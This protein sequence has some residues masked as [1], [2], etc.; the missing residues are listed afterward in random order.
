[1][2]I[3]SANKQHPVPQNVM[4]VE[5]KLIGELT[6]RQFSY[7]L[8]FAVIAFLT[9]KTGL[10]VIFKYP[11][12]LVF[13]LSGLAFA[14][15]PFND[16]TLDKWVS[17][18]IRAVTN[19]RFRV[20]KHIQRVPYYFTLDAKKQDQNNSQIKQVYNQKQRGSI[21]EFL[22]KNKPSNVAFDD[23]SDI[24]ATENEFFSKLGL[25]TSNKTVKPISQPVTQ[26]TPQGE[27]VKPENLHKEMFEDETHTK[28][29]YTSLALDPTLPVKTFQENAKPLS[30]QSDTDNAKKQEKV[31]AAQYQ[32][33]LKELDSLKKQLL[34]DIEKN[35]FKIRDD[36]KTEIQNLNS[37]ASISNPLNKNLGTEEQLKNREPSLKQ[38][39]PAEEK[40]QDMIEQKT[41]QTPQP[42]TSLFKSLFSALGSN[43]AADKVEVQPTNNTTEVK[44]KTPALNDVKPNILKGNTQ[45]I[46]GNIIQD[47]IVIIKNSD[48]DPVRALKT[49]AL[50]E[51]EVSTPLD[52]GSYKIEA[53]KEGFSFTPIEV[54]ASGQVINPVKLIGTQ[55]TVLS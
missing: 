38:E 8:V 54:N 5:F 29:K 6:I 34:K 13:I 53:I 18:Y 43:T 40:K 24:Q 25:N 11:L 22:N 20:W 36:K 50:G 19:P 37:N 35:K 9:A 33:H 30:Q 16:I 41:T 12:I 26:S 44:E 17:N 51:F 55:V 1:M 4:D 52:E 15:L 21:E 46:H 10:P 23:E 2:D 31:N 27:K 45:D 49:N 28:D 39:I 7:L 42:K 47:T 14:F 32:E 3:Q 48:N